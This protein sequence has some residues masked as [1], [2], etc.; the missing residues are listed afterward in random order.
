MGDSTTCFFSLSIWQRKLFVAGNWLSQEADFHKCQNTLP[1]QK[2]RQNILCWPLAN[3]RHS[4]SNE[5]KE[6]ENQ[7]MEKPIKGGRA[8]PWTMNDSTM[9]C[10]GISMQYPSCHESMGSMNLVS[11]PSLVI[12]VICGIRRS[13][14]G[15][16]FILSNGW[17]G[18][19]PRRVI[20]TRILCFVDL[21]NV[22][23]GDRS[24]QDTFCFNGLRY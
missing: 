12:C 14:S 11:L 20:V 18:F 1:V 10:E 6:G 23:C 24:R 13:C 22:H 17:N 7:R 2:P 8:A 9:R 5:M 3:L 21:F 19:A 4:N 15:P 16:L